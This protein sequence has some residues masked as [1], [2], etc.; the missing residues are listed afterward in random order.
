[1]LETI[2]DDI[3]NY[4]NNKNDILIASAQPGVSKKKNSYYRVSL[5][6]GIK[7]L[8]F[9][10]KEKLFPGQKVKWSQSQEPFINIQVIENGTTT[11]KEV[12]VQEKVL[13][14]VLKLAPSGRLSA[15]KVNSSSSGSV[16]VTVNSSS[17]SSVIDLSPI[18]SSTG[19]SLPLVRS[20]SIPL[21]SGS[22][23]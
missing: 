3:E 4:L 8:C 22:S 14:V 6:N 13:V 1:M 11:Q 2:N 20:I 10:F 18:G 23:I 16:A 9:N 17:S 15:E 21:I 19:A 7:G 12:G 5:N